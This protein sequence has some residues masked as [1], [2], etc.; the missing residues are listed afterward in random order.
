LGIDTAVPCGL[1]I[2]E[3]VSNALKFAFPP[4][5]ER[6]A[7]EGNEIR[8]ELYA[9]DGDQLTLVVGDNGVGLPPDLDWQ[10]SP[11]LGLQLVRM[12]TRQLQGTIELDQSV[13]TAFK[14]T[15]AEL[16][17]AQEVRP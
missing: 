13:G 1:I 5:R 10:D 7:G 3:L 6:P 4:E 9:R 14:I 15:F 11:S 2:N 17:P 8:I 12:L 16:K